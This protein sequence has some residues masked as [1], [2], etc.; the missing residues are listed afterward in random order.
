M[1]LLE[2]GVAV[3]AIALLAGV[4]V[5]ARLA[6]RIGRAADEV[7][8]AARGVAELTPTA[9]EL[10]ETGSEVTNR[11]RAIFAGARA[12]FGVLRRFRDDN[13]SRSVESDEVDH[14]ER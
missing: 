10:I 12:G 3:I 4:F 9:R 11:Y 2:I 6:P 1:N 7:A 14:I 5:L 13:G 8:L